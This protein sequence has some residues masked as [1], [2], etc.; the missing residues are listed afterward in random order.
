[1]FCIQDL[2]TGQYAVLING[3]WELTPNVAQADHQWLLAELAELIAVTEFPSPKYQAVVL[4][5]P[6]P[7]PPAP[8]LVMP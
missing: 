4:P 8:I 6:P 7:S 3:T 1:M 5:W 2:L